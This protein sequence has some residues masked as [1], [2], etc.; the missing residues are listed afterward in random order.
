MR[1]LTTSDNRK[2]VGSLVEDVGEAVEVQSVF[3]IVRSEIKAI[4]LTP[5][6]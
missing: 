3:V 5:P 2:D 4:R 1:L 6:K